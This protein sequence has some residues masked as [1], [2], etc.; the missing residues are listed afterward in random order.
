MLSL[1][2]ISKRSLIC[3]YGKHH[4]IQ[5]NLLSSLNHRNNFEELKVK[6]VMRREKNGWN[7]WTISED[8]TVYEATKKMVEH[9]NGSLCV[10][11]NQKVV[12]ILTERDYL[13]KVVHQ[14]RTSKDTL[15]HEISTMGNR[16]IVAKLNDDIQDCV[17]VMA[18]QNIRHLPVIQEDGN[19]IGLLSI[20][21]IAKALS[22]E[23]HSVLRTLNDLRTTTKMPIHDG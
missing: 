3:F 9:K 18:A 1:Q 8:E 2:R 22:K 7:Q 20:R 17:D 4:R 12:G 5:N 19:V 21:D 15:V 13:E 11:R 10:L 16:L 6:D 14:G 23:R